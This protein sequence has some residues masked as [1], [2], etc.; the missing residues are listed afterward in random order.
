MGEALMN[1]P[2]RVALVAVAAVAL[3]DCGSVSTETG[4]SGADTQ[5][6]WTFTDE[7]IDLGIQG[8][9]PGATVLPNGTVR[10]Y[11]TAPNGGAV[12]EA[13]DGLAFH[14]VNGTIPGTVPTV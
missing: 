7:G 14:L 2:A 13:T 3:T 8:V 10:L 6:G 1:H 11:V 4:G 9:S 5:G 12:Y